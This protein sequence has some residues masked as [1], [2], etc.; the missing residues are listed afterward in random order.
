MSEYK[1]FEDIFFAA[2]GCGCCHRMTDPKPAD[3]EQ[4]LRDKIATDIWLEFD[5]DNR[6]VWLADVLSRCADIA[7]GQK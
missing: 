5:G 3:V 4:W 1:T 6:E 7:R 2:A